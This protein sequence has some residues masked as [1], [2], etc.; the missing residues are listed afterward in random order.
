MIILSIDIGSKNTAF[1][2]EDIEITEDPH[3][4]LTSGTIQYWGINGFEQDVYTSAINMCKSMIHI[5]ED[6]DL[7]LIEQ[8]MRTNAKAMEIQHILHTIFV[9]YGLPVEIVSSKLKTSI[10]G[11]KL[12]THYQRKKWAV[13]FVSQIND[14]GNLL[15]HAKKKDDFADSFLQCKA[16]LIHKYTKEQMYDPHNITT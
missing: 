1:Y 8:Q 5:F 13:S 6:C 9:S 16:Y 10:F 12:S 2:K 15:K 14:N 4:L 7:V 11:Q 3:H